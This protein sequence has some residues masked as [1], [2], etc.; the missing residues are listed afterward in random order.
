MRSINIQSLSPSLSVS[1]SLSSILSAGC[2]FVT[3]ATT[4][5]LNQCNSNT[6]QENQPPLPPLSLS[7]FSYICTPSPPPTLLL[8]CLSVSINKKV[9]SV[10]HIWQQ[11]N[12]ETMFWHPT[13]ISVSLGLW[14]ISFDIFGGILNLYYLEIDNYK[15][16]TLYI[17]INIY[18]VTL[19]YKKK[20][21][22]KNKK[23]KIGS[24]IQNMDKT[25]NSFF[26]SLRQIFLSDFLTLTEENDHSQR[27]K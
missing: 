25:Q 11:L 14:L 23:P 12:Q 21:K 18:W 9:K 3:A 7:N 16:V 15:Q 19:K 8:F 2:W 10:N 24:A 20:H 17:Y 13:S 5:P 6:G 27:K 26:F 22:N 1:L 4:P